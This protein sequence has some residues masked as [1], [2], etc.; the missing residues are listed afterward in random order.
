MMAGERSF[1]LAGMSMSTGPPY[2]GSTLRR[3]TINTR[4]KRCEFPFLH[5][6]LKIIHQLLLA[7]SVRIGHQIR[8]FADL[9]A[10]GLECFEATGK[11][12]TEQFERLRGVK[13]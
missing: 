2:H 10:T 12:F 8:E 1:A 11:R 6:G 13:T 3:L 9:G 4:T 5:D 7:A